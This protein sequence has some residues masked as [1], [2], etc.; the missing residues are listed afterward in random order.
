M[1]GAIDVP[2]STTNDD[3]PINHDDQRSYYHVPCIVGTQQ[4]YTISRQSTMSTSYSFS[5]SDDDAINPPRLPGTTTTTTST[6]TTTYSCAWS[7]CYVAG[8]LIGCTLPGVEPHDHCPV[9]GCRSGPFH[10]C[11]QTGWEMAQYLHDIVPMAIRVSVNMNQVMGK[12]IAW[13]TT[14]LV[15]LLFVLRHQKKWRKQQ[16]RQRPRVSYIT[17]NL[18][19]LYSKNITE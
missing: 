17:I 5:D 2:P 13:S 12:N 4:S 10:H 18:I 9:K 3:Q 1:V 8:K 11:C 15:T 7:E 6:S 16:Q 19:L 14:N